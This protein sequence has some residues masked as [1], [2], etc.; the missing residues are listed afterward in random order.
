[1]LLMGLGEMCAVLLA[2]RALQSR[3]L[4]RTIQFTPLKTSD[5]EQLN[6]LDD[7][8]GGS[9]GRGGVLEMSAFALPK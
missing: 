3:V 9:G 6:G 7:E 1:M 5:G 2:L 8:E 4:G